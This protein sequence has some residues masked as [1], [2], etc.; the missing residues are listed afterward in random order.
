MNYCWFMLIMVQCDYVVN[1]YWCSFGGWIMYGLLVET[2]F[3]V[4]LFVLNFCRKRRSRRA[5]PEEQKVSYLDDCRR[6]TMIQ[7]LHCLCLTW[8]SPGIPKAS[9][10]HWATVTRFWKMIFS[11]VSI[12]PHACLIML[13]ATCVDYYVYYAWFLSMNWGLWLN[14][15]MIR[16]L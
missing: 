3:L 7:F 6:A 14:D 1:V 9:Q 13:C 10:P 15:N 11:L 16:K 2:S 5:S 8:G 4:V 12:V